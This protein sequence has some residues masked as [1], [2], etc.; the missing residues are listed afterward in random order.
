MRR[1]CHVFRVSL[2]LSFI[3]V[4]AGTAGGETVLLNEDTEYVLP[5]NRSIWYNGSYTF[6]SENESTLIVTGGD[7]SGKFVGNGTALLENFGMVYIRDARNTWADTGGGNKDFTGYGRGGVFAA[8][9]ESNAEVQFINNANVYFDSITYDCS[10]WGA[11]S[12]LSAVYGGAIYAESGG[13]VLF[14]GNGYVSLNSTGICNIQDTN[15]SYKD[16]YGYG[17]AVYAPLLS[18]ISTKSDVDIKD[19]Y[20]RQGVC[21]DAEGYGMGGAV[22]AEN[23]QM[24]HNGSNITFSQNEI[25][26]AN[27]ARGGA[28]YLTGTGEIQDNELHVHFSGNSVTAAPDQNYGKW[29]DSVSADCLAYGGAVFLK[30]NAGLTVSGNAGNVHVTGNTATADYTNVTNQGEGSSHMDDSAVAQGG[31]VYLGSGA[32]LVIE[33]NGQDGKTEYGNVNFRDNKVQVFG[34]S[35]TTAQ[36]GAVYL[37]AASSFVVQGNSGAVTFAG[38]SAEEG[39]GIYAAGGSVVRISD[40]ANGVTF[41]QNTASMFG[42]AVYAAGSVEIN[43]NAF[44]R[45]SDNAAYTGSAV[46]AASQAQVSMS[47]NGDIQFSSS[48]DHNTVVYLNADAVFSV[49]DNGVVSISAVSDRGV[50]HAGAGSRTDISGNAGVEIRG[51]ETVNDGVFLLSGTLRMDNNTGTIVLSDNIA[52]ASSG[53]VIT[54]EGE[55]AS[56]SLSGNRGDIQIHNNYAGKSGAVVYAAAAGSSVYIC[57]NTN[58]SVTGNEARSGAA[59]IDITGNLHIRNNSGNVI[60]GNNSI[61]REESNSYVLQSIHAG[62]SSFSAADGGSLEFRDSVSVSGSLELNADYNSTEQD[63][64]IIFTG[65]YTEEYARLYSQNNV[66]TEKS[67]LS[68]VEGNISLHNGSLTVT[69]RAVLQ[70][71]SFT[72]ETDRD[73]RLVLSAGG[74]LEVY[75]P[76]VFGNDTVLQAGIAELEPELWSDAEFFVPDL[77]SLFREMPISG[78]L[79]C[80]E[81]ILDSGSTY[82]LDGGILDLVGGQLTLAEGAVITLSGTNEWV[83]VGDERI[84]LLFSGVT[85]LSADGAVLMYDGQQFSDDD[86]VFNGEENIVYLRTVSVPEP[87]VPVLTLVGSSLLLLRRRR[88]G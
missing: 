1:F 77:A 52:A 67:R 8:K 59:G 34:T 87:S 51:C 11:N 66:E 72:V 43:D 33:D 84:L 75:A 81:L 27:D 30:D 69:E 5:T 49:C 58:V 78:T 38:N 88:K 23:L 64:E 56:F 25:D 16:F 65:K 70:A 12:T 22:Y 55:G 47:G 32:K 37:S 68:S 85:G 86:L 35:E 3:C 2:G 24:T 62:E 19:C 60:F 31:A 71:E 41:E 42:G 6:R 36:G 7:G 9:L 14:E 26:V 80:P 73:A 29:E 40:N 4:S 57:D 48:V 82:V 50:L 63:G 61:Y 20:I 79:D 53:G 44:V 83:Q 13:K 46:Y 18:I 28:V 74:T 39:G 10:D 45:F 21:T 15:Y 76:I 54:L 17:G